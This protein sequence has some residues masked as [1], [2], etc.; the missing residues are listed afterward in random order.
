MPRRALNN[1]DILLEIFEHLRPCAS[2]WPDDSRNMERRTTLARSARV[3]RSFSEPALRVLW[4]SLDDLNPPFRLLRTLGI[5]ELECIVG[6]EAPEE[7]F[8]TLLPPEIPHQAWARFQQ[9]ASHVRVVHARMRQSKS[10]VWIALAS[11]IGN[12]P[13]FPCLQSIQLDLDGSPCMKMLCLMAPS[14]NS[15]AISADSYS[16]ESLEAFLEAVSTISPNAVWRLYTLFPSLFRHTAFSRFSSLRKV[17]ITCTTLDP[18]LD[19]PTSWKRL[20]QSAAEK[21]SFTCPWKATLPE[22]FM[23][24]S[25]PQLQSAHILIRGVSDVTDNR[26][27]FDALCFG[28]P[29]L[30]ILNLFF[31]SNTEHSLM[32]LL[33]PLLAL[34]GM[35]KLHISATA[36]LCVSKDDI[37]TMAQSWP[38]LESLDMNYTCVEPAPPIQSIVEFAH[39]CPHLHRL[40]FP[41]FSCISH[42]F[43][44]TSV[45]S[46][47]CERL[48]ELQ[49]LDIDVDDVE[50]CRK[51]AEFIEGIFPGEEDLKDGKV[52]DAEH[53]LVIL[54][55]RC[56][57]TAYAE[58]ALGSR[59]LSEYWLESGIGGGEAFDGGHDVGVLCL[60]VAIVIVD[61]VEGHLERM[62]SQLWKARVANAPLPCRQTWTQRL[63]YFA[64]SARGTD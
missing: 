22:L 25:F 46:P 24:F 8:N 38:E 39:H 47:H 30:C 51:A 11:R 63:W 60:S 31:A 59:A 16:D 12:Q 33:E 45:P 34:T 15:L 40:C 26:Q 44:P 64:D 49:G 1:F 54:S 50:L 7:I 62:G 42:T 41:R 61:N 32:K 13:L 14:V 56:V 55:G 29:S 19:S 28:S 3:C 5:L 4:W 21:I 53:G 43:P 20:L 36:H 48:L 6:E 27:I 10:S 9:Y 37:R 18:D 35:K 23:D 57:R 58:L 2:N 52:R 17:T